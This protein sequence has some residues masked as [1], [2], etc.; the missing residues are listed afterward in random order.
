LLRDGEPCSHRGCL[1][2]ISH[3]CEGC[4]RIRGYRTI[5]ST[6]ESDKYGLH[7]TYDGDKHKIMF[8][9]KCSHCGEYFEDYNISLYCLDCCTNYI[10]DMRSVMKF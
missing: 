8:G 3:P 5:E 10:A 6:I 2:H 7:I 1:N 4:G 9:G